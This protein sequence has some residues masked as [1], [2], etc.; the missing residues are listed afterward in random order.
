MVPDWGSLGSSG[1]KL[2]PGSVA[3]APGCEE[4]AEV[5][6]ADDPVPVQA[7]LRIV[8]VPAGQEIPQVFSVHGIVVT[9]D[10]LPAVIAPGVVV[11]T[12]EVDD[13]PWWTDAI[14]RTSRSTRDDQLNLPILKRMTF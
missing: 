2:L 7:A 8:G 13:R 4:Q 6:G 1:I 9:V 12:A 14:D 10:V 5:A 11:V 3:R